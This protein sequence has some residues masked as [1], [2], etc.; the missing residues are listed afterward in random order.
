MNC[1]ILDD[2]ILT[3][4]QLTS[5][6]HRSDLLELKACFSN[7]KEVSDF[8]K[9]NQIDLIFL[10]I[11]MPLMSGLEFLGQANYD[12]S[13]IIISGNRKYALNTYEY[14]V[15][16]YLVKPIEFPRFLKSIY[17]IIEKDHDKIKLDKTDRIFIKLANK[18]ERIKFSNIL[19][20]Q[21]NEKSTSL[22]TR[23]NNYT[24][25]CGKFKFEN[26]LKNN[27]S[28]K[29]THNLII[30]LKEISLISNNKIVFF[31]DFVLENIE[32]DSKT[33]E[34]LKIKIKELQN[35]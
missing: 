10:D 24:L 11:E 31:N 1:I 6:I 15:S 9:N 12:S 18:Y 34:N 2:D 7:P 13:I 8:I 22:V 32:I 35:D 30:N 26:F 19:F 33:L 25:T 23:K 27:F 3:Q 29:L 5:F 4:K 21:N 28:F 16:D 14:K 17:K 20:I